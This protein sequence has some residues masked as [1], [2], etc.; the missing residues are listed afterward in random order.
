[1]Q[2][3]CICEIKVIREDASDDT[4]NL[5]HMNKV[6]FQNQIYILASRLI[7]LLDVEPR[8]HFR[9]TGRIGI[10]CLGRSSRYAGDFGGSWHL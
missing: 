3:R 7:D 10:A 4:R 6:T 8:S 5:S 9:L 2:S 1:M